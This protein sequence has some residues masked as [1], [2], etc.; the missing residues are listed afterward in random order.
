MLENYTRLSIQA[1]R[2]VMPALLVFGLALAAA[3][4]PAAANSD[5]DAQPTCRKGKVWDKRKKMCV[6]AQSGV[7]DDESIAENAISLAR[8]ERYVEALQVLALAK[9]QNNPKI[10]NYRGYATRKLGRIDEGIKFY[11]QALAM[12]P[13]NVLVRSYLGEAYLKKG[14]KGKAIALLKEIRDRC[15]TDCKEYQTLSDAI[16]AAG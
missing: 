14:E 2:F 12:D 11:N 5:D 15:G 16:G 8:E 6:P 9:D 1:R 13:D 7:I 3:M 10:L 4:E